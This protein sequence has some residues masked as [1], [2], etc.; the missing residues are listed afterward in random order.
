[1][2]KLNGKSFPTVQENIEK[3]KMLFPEIVNTGG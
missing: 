3:L 1:M 2:L